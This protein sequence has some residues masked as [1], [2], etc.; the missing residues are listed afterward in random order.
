MGAFAGEF[1]V[2]CGRC[3][4]SSGRSCTPLASHL[5]TRVTTGGWSSPHR[6]PPISRASW[7]TSWKRN[8]EAKL[9][10]AESPP[11]VLDSRVAYRGHIFDTVVETIHLT[12]LERPV[13]VE[14]VRHAPSVGIAAMPT[15][16][17]V[18][19]VRQYR[20]ALSAW[21]WELPAGSVDAGERAEDAARRECHEEL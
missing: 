17:S 6:C 3:R 2:T 20:H 11:A 9:M 15:D 21:L 5:H 14:V 10:A 4:A 19:L 1:R 8:N 13:T 18:M 12:T 7:T 16:D